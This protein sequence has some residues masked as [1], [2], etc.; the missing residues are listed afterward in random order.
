MLHSSFLKFPL[1]FFNV[2]YSAKIY[3]FVRVFSFTSL[4]IVIIA[5][6][7][8]KF[9]FNFPLLPSSTFFFFKPGLF[10]A[11]LSSVIQESSREWGRAY[12]QHWA[13]LLRFSSLWS[14]PSSPTS[15]C[16]H[17]GLF[18][19]LDRQVTSFFQK[20]LPAAVTTAHPRTKARKMGNLPGVNHLLPNFSS[21]T[22]SASLCSP[23]RGFRQY[24]SS[25][26]SIYV[27]CF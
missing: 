12:T 5:G 7:K 8:S 18:F 1:D 20:Q 19:P 16:G 2:F 4:I 17:P 10:T 11:C 15:G 21:P 3:F 13:P 9:Q 26:P 22:N 25:V 23:Y 27:N 24:F 6:L 14:A